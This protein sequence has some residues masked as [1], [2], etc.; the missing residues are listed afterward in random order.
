MDKCSTTELLKATKTKMTDAR[1][2]ILNILLESETPLTANELHIAVSDSSSIDLATVYRALKVFVE[3][4]LARALHIDGETIYY[5]KACEHNPLHA[6]F[7][8]EVCG[9]VECLNPF[10][11]DESSA[12]M[13]MAKDKEISSVELVIKGRCSKCV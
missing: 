3:K 1:S 7:H 10:G 9:A 12:F 5:E 8:C 2:K 11:F 4:G 6:H 13:K